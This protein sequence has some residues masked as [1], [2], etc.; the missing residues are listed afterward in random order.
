VTADLDTARQK[1]SEA[2]A[3][4]QELETRLQEARAAL[5]EARSAAESTRATGREHEA[6]ILEQDAL[7]REQSITIRT[8]EDRLASEG[9]QVREL[10]NRL[11]EI[12]SRMRENEIR[13]VDLESSLNRARSDHESDRSHLL[14]ELEAERNSAH[15]QHRILTADV[16]SFRTRA[17]VA[18][19]DLEIVQRKLKDA[20]S[21]FDDERRLRHT[22]ENNAQDWES[23]CRD[24]EDQANRV[25]MAGGGRYVPPRAYIPPAPLPAPPSLALLR[26]AERILD[27]KRAADNA[28]DSDKASLAMAL[29]DAAMG[30]AQTAPKSPA[31]RT[32]PPPSRPLGN[33]LDARFDK[34]GT[35]IKRLDD[36]FKGFQSSASRTYETS[37]ARAASR[38]VSWNEVESRANE[39]ARVAHSAQGY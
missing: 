5:V 27:T 2:H 6:R 12:E 3:F 17:S 30:L 35:S 32:G 16:D 15:D 8:L 28:E 37:A 24:L 26:E 7:I 21:S 36:K 9:N 10:N 19:A 31:R 29:V 38:H 25:V 1:G 13:A 14:R 23:R 11:L 4:V 33:R 18:E 34:L 39:F 20:L 22:A